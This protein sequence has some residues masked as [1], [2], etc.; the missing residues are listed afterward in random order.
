MFSFIGKIS[1]GKIVMFL[2]IG[3]IIFGLASVWAL[4]HFFESHYNF[5]E[6][7]SIEKKISNLKNMALLYAVKNG[8][9]YANLSISALQ[10]DKIITSENWTIKK[11]WGYPLNQNIIQVYWIR[12][13]GYNN[14]PYYI[15][16]KDI[17]LIN[18]QA[19]LV[20]R[21]FENDIN[22]VYYN[23]IWHPIKAN[24]K[25]GKIIPKNESFVPGR[26]MYLSFE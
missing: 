18:N 10:V 8:G 15:G 19:Y 16:F 21:Y 6:S 12:S 20:C 2:L 3:L 25:C 13:G 17:S 5:R 24:N 9:N 26:E 23:K 22:A 14:S 1:S 7:V 11:G 4:H